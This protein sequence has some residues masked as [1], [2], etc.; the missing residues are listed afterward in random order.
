MFR[1]VTDLLMVVCLRL[2]E[3]HTF[4]SEDFTDHVRNQ[5]SAIRCNLL[6][7]Q[8]LCLMQIYLVDFSFRSNPRHSEGELLNT[9]LLS[10][11]CFRMV[12]L[13]SH[14]VEVLLVSIDTH[15]SGS[16]YI[17]IQ[18]GVPQ[19]L[20]LGPIFYNLYML[21]LGD[22][23]RRNPLISTA[24]LMIHNFTLLCIL[25]IFSQ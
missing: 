14:R 13:L 16:Q 2:A 9:E 15:S 4:I 24:M 8:V 21:P 1:H 12:L 19:G 3:P 11:Y 5:I 20:M 17:D 10:S 7:C 6:S 22:V 23:I 25:M 18:C